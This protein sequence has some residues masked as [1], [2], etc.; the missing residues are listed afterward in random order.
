MG[1][2]FDNLLNKTWFL[3]CPKRY[4]SNTVDKSEEPDRSEFLQRVAS[5]EIIVPKVIICLDISEL[6]SMYVLQNFRMQYLLYM[7][8]ARQ[9]LE[10][11]SVD[12][13]RPFKITRAIP[14][15]L[16]TIPPD[17]HKGRGILKLCDALGISPSQVL[18]F[19]D[20]ENDV[21]M[22]RVVGYPVAMANAMSAAISASKYVTESNDQGGVGAF[23]EKIWN[24]S[25]DASK[26]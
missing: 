19:G 21:D 8:D 7:L 10:K 26:L 25:E 1:I 11:L 17:V 18:A 5:G 9:L 15:I 2:L 24:F 16:E 6:D 20:G 12:P 4:E 22:F 23:I 13:C 14:W 3:I